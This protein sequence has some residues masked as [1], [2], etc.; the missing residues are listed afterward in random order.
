VRSKSELVIADKLYSRSIE[1]AY[2]QPLA[3]GEGRLRYPDFT[4]RIMRAA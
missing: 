4:S 1:Y 3:I 2:E